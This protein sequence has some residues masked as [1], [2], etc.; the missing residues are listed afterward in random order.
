MVYPQGSV[1]GPLLFLLYIN[2]LPNVSNKLYFH[3]FA[4]DTNIFFESSNLVT[5]QTTANRENGQKL[6]NWLNS[7][8]LALNVSKTNFVLF[9]AKTNL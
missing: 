8:R 2:D 9:S 3:L 4:D 1:L 5:L 6:V 7:N